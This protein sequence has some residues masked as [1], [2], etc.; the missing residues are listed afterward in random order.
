MLIKL[1]FGS[2]ALHVRAPS[3]P[4]VCPRPHSLCLSI[5][6]L[7]TSFLV[8]SLLLSKQ[9]AVPLIPFLFGGEKKKKKETEFLLVQRAASL[10]SFS[11]NH[12]SPPLRASS[13][14]CPVLVIRLDFLI[15]RSILC[16]IPR[17]PFFCSFEVLP[18]SLVSHPHTSRAL[19]VMM[20]DPLYSPH[21]VLT[22]TCVFPISAHHS[23]SFSPLASFL[24]TRFFF[25][26]EV[27]AIQ[28]FLLFFFFHL[29][30]SSPLNP[31]SSFFPL[32]IHSP[33]PLHLLLYLSTPGN[34]SCQFSSLLC[35]FF[36]LSL[37]LPPFFSSKSCFF[38]FSPSPFFFL[39]LLL[40]IA[41]LQSAR[42][43][44]SKTQSLAKYHNA[45]IPTGLAQ[46]QT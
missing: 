8:F 26:P 35:Y 43:P 29:L 31:F 30:S 10:L 7:F 38:F 24:Q 44:K 13:R 17:L 9:E 6:V 33:C 46:M 2:L 5:T 32:P 37:N 20:S 45:K 27:R 28:L 39:S 1:L 42:P 34:L 19:S 18:S 12:T 21:L 15:F 4:P 3:A 16:F 22:S 23:S 41:S 14:R 36:Q 25:I 40:I 11:Y